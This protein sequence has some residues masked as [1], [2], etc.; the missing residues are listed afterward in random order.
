MTDLSEKSKLQ[1][2]QSNVSKT[3]T[4]PSTIIQNHLKGIKYSIQIRNVNFISLN[5]DQMINLFFFN[6]FA[7]KK[8]LPPCSLPLHSTARP[9]AR[10]VAWP[11][12]RRCGTASGPLLRPVVASYWEGGSHSRHPRPRY[13]WEA[14]LWK[15]LVL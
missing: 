8:H 5:Y 12:L 1:T 14:Q 11:P 3:K 4:Q 10:D 6:S 2:S 13:L 7:L 9:S 15:E